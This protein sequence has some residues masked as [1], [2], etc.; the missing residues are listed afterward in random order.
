MSDRLPL[1]RWCSICDIDC[2]YNWFQLHLS[3]YLPVILCGN[4][5]SPSCYWWLSHGTWWKTAMFA[6][7]EVDCNHNISHL[8]HLYSCIY[9]Y[10]L[11]QIHPYSLHT[12][13]GRFPRVFKQTQK[14]LGAMTPVADRNIPQ[15]YQPRSPFSTS[16][17]CILQ[18][19]HR[20]VSVWF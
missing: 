13:L 6:C 16:T 17:F 20:L 7:Q 18:C 8:S 11:I 4:G 15:F 19:L 3:I 9:I 10:S 1:K 14:C 5:K 12:S 2:L